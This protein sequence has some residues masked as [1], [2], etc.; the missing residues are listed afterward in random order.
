MNPYR[1]KS[2][3][4]IAIGMT[5]IDTLLA[6]YDGAI[7]RLRKAI[8]FLQVGNQPQSMPLIARVQL[9]VSELAAGVRLD[10]DET[11]GT[12]YLRLYEF[13]VHKLTKGTIPDLQEV[14]KLM[15]ILRD[16][17]MSIRDEAVSMERRGELAPADSL[18]LL[19]ETA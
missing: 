17:F 12:N 2:P 18:Q 19:C 7:E 11:L 10:V 1:P 15:G 8:L 14:L 6:L 5:R 13:F 16:G 4:P 9:I 3:A